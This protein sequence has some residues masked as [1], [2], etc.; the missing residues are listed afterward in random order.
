MFG[1]EIDFCKNC[2]QVI[3]REKFI[4]KAY[5]VTEKSSLV[6]ISGGTAKV[7][8][9]LKCLNSYLDKNKKNIIDKVEFSNRDIYVFKKSFFERAG[10]FILSPVSFWKK[11]T[12]R[13]GTIG[14]QQ[15]YELPH[16]ESQILNDELKQTEEQYAKQNND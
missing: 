6:S 10:D 4:N 3:S 2:H 9:C 8:A 7:E 12:E 15:V 13:L 14:G 5:Y 11:L 1:D 16:Q